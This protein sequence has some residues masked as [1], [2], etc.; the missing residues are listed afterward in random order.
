MADPVNAPEAGFPSGTGTGTGPG[1]DSGAG[2]IQP[3][4]R[5]IPHPA[6]DGRRA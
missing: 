5:F 3:L 1:A 2:S 4:V 6:A